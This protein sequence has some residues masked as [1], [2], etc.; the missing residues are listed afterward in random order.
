[1]NVTGNVYQVAAGSILTSALNFGTVQVGQAVSQNLTVKNTATGATGYVEDLNA[2]F[3][4]TTGT[5]SNLISGS[6]SIS[7]LI[8]GAS[9]NALTVSVN[10][11]AA[12]TVNGSIAVNYV[13]AGA[14]N[15]VSNGLGT[16]AVGS[17]SYGVA[18]T[19]AA[20]ANVINQA[21]PVVN[22][23][24]IALGNVRIGTTSP[25][26]SV[27]V[28]N[29]ST[30]SPQAALD[31]SIAGNA[32]I[33]A[34]GSFNLLSPGSTDASSL[35]VGLDTSTAGAK[36]GTATISFISDANNVGGCGTNCQLTLA[37]QN[38]AVSGAVYRLANPTVGSATTLAARVGGSASTTIGVTNSS[39]DVYT[40]ALTATR[41]ATAA[42]FTSSGSITNLAAQ[43]T[44]NA[45]TVALNTTAAGTFTGTQALNFVSTGAGTDGAAD[46]A[47]ASQNVTLNGKV[48]TPA[49]AQANTASVNFGIVH[50]GASVSQG[51]SVTNA[52]PVTALNDVL[53][54]SAI[55]ATGPF[56]A[57]GSLGAGLA[58]G[59]TSTN[60]L[61]VG[62]NTT[63]AGTYSG[64]ATFSAASHDGDLS[65]AALSNLAISL[66]GQV[67]NYATD[68]FKLAGGSG[69]LSQ[70]GT[71]Y[72]LDFGS[73]VKGSGTESATLVAGNTATGPADL[74]DGSFQ[75]LDPT[76]FGESGFSA[77]ANLAAGQ[78]TGGLGLTF[79]TSTVGTFMDTIV[80]SGLGH[81]ASGYSGAL[82]DIE[83]VVRG[84]VTTQA[85]TGVPEPATLALFGLGIPLLLR[86]RS[87]KAV[88]NG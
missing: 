11:S 21:S 33:T 75:F 83:L 18:G 77:F 79:D 26:A 84:T 27:S 69:S 46:L 39:P 49:V 87:R 82:G 51:V 67:N 63:T 53:V 76:D 42:G 78:N 3:G 16:L 29:Q 36:N 8:A 19:I 38:V 24:T 47:L 73:V 80:L 14:V 37:S 22:T 45:I 4:S 86:R 50:V 31:A 40:E 48:Y 44:S 88:A 2:S 32:P 54:A 12:G 72:T 15:G 10:T 74:L 43:G 41:G 9:S 61:Q 65:D 7:G 28:T 30:A 23:P 85:T 6:G 17:D 20:S 71:V 62:L 35:K 57:S 1:M 68:A 56:T 59:Q 60:G 58:A 70:S 5:G 25:S 81:N 13:S 64:S 55:G 52:A 34:S 66:S